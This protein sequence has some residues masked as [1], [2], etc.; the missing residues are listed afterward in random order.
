VTRTRHETGEAFLVPSRNR[1]STGGRIP[2]HP[3]GRRP[4]TRRG[5]RGPSERGSGGMPVERRGSVT[6][7]GAGQL[8][9]G[10]LPCRDRSMGRWPD[11]SRSSAHASPG[12]WRAARPETRCRHVVAVPGG[13][14]SR[15]WRASA[16]RPL[17]VDLLVS[18]QGRATGMGSAQRRTGA[19]EPARWNEERV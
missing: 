9:I 11:C 13:E 6:E 15:H 8:F 14:E 5:R 12:R 10:G 16:A 7:L 19:P 4:Q 17:T 2:G 1:W 18:Y 3:P